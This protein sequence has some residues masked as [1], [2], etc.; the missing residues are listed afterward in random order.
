MHE[1]PQTEIFGRCWP[2]LI[3][4]ANFM[5]SNH[6][7]GSNRRQ[8]A[9]LLNGAD[10]ISQSILFQVI[11]RLNL[12]NLLLI[13][14]HR[15]SLL[16]FFLLTFRLGIDQ[17]CLRVTSEGE[18]VE[19]IRVGLVELVESRQLLELEIVSTAFSEHYL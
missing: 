5:T 10:S 4:V 18:T 12:D 16:R 7:E 2:K 3:V 11:F 19:L 17:H 1:L 15:L 9:F 13:G 14:V 8:L 6:L